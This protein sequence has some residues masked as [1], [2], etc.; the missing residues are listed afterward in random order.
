MKK[1]N[2][3]IV[4]DEENILNSVSRVLRRGYYQIFTAKRGE[5][6]LALLKHHDIH[7][8]I[9]D[10]K[11]PGMSG[12]DFLKQVKS[13]YPQIVTIMLTGHADIEIAM[14]AINDAGVYKFILKPWDDYDLKITVRRALEALE[15]VC[16]RDSLMQ[17]VK[18][19]DALLGDL[20]KE[21]PGIRNIEHDEDGSI[22]MDV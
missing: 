13:D 16:E 12:I 21:F 5:E 3:L 15:L 4:D 1:Y 7:M 20:E 18:A 9:S 10:Q 8:V 17:Q 22:I 2:I 19:Q 11:M 14:N 6:G